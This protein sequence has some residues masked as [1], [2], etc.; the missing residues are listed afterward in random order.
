MRGWKSSLG[1]LVMDDVILAKPE[2]SPKKRVLRD[3]GLTL[4]AVMI[5][6]LLFGRPYSNWFYALLALL[7]ITSV[8]RILK[9]KPRQSGPL[10]PPREVR[11]S[12]REAAFQGLTSGLY[13]FTFMYTAV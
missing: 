13:F 9:G 6:V 4:L 5:L 12:L 3:E 7:V 1:G 8:Y 2:M 11:A 10:N